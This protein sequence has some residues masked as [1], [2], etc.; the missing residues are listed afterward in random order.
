MS[1]QRKSLTA[2]DTTVRNILRVIGARRNGLSVEGYDRLYAQNWSGFTGTGIK[3]KMAFFFQITCSRPV[4]AGPH[5]LDKKSSP[6]QNE[7]EAHF[8]P[9]PK[10]SG[11]RNDP[12]IVTPYIK[13]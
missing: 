1:G 9:T 3:Q 6:N 10:K 7:I 13:K 5:W 4:S 8:L 11:L 2:Q 12:K